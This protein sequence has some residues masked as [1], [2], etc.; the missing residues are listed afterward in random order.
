MVEPQ[1]L[2]LMTYVHRPQLQNDLANVLRRSIEITADLSRS[3]SRKV[4]SDCPISAEPLLESRVPDLCHGDVWRNRK[5]ASY[6]GFANAAS[7]ASG[8]FG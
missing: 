4:D 1:L 3:C 7:V 5:S 6:V 8:C 2:K